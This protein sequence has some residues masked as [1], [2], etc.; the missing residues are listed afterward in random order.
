MNTNITPREQG[1][2]AGKKGKNITD[3]PYMDDTIEY[4]EWLKGI[5]DFKSNIPS[6]L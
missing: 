5:M 2:K 1:F 3:N 4:M 6:G